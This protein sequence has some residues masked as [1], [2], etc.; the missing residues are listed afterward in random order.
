M[1]KN[2]A[3]IIEH[4]V[5]HLLSQGV[6]HVL[7]ADNLSTDSTADVLASLSAELPIHVA[8]DRDPAHYQAL[9]MG[10]LADA[11]R[12]AGADWVGAL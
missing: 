5:R 4:T 9:K 6:D 11:A 12:R 10:L 1:V 3:D 2:E 8:K 7:V